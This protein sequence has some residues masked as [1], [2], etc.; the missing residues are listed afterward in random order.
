M[1]KLVSLP[2]IRLLQQPEIASA[3]GSLTPKVETA[4]P[5]VTSLPQSGNVTPGVVTINNQVGSTTVPPSYWRNPSAPI[6]IEDKLDVLRGAGVAGLLFGIMLIICV[7]ISYYMHVV[8]FVNT[9]FMTEPLKL[10]KIE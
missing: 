9:K 7:I 2:R 8:I 6:T 5:I 1:R 10:G 4:L 3:T